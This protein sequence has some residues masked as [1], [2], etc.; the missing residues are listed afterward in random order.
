MS[1]SNES[2]GYISFKMSTSVLR[3]TT[4]QPDQNTNRQDSHNRQRENHAGTITLNQ[5]TRTS[6][7]QRAKEI[8]H[9][10]VEAISE[11][12]VLQ[13]TMTGNHAVQ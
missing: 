3:V 5:D 2:R 11:T 9:N 8:H 10:K 6:S 7:R 12:P 13:A 4:Q 1:T